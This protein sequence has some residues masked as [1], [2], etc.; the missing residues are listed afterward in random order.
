NLY[1]ADTKVRD[2]EVV[3]ER[4]DNGGIGHSLQLIDGTEH[5][6]FRFV[7]IVDNRL[8]YR[9]VAR[10]GVGARSEAERILLQKIIRDGQGT[11]VVE[12]LFPGGGVAFE[13]LKDLDFTLV[14]S[15]FAGL[16]NI[17]GDQ[18]FV[19]AGLAVPLN[20]GVLQAGALDL[21]VDGGRIGSMRVLHVDQRPAA[22]VDAQ[23]D[24][25]PERHGKH[26]SHAEDQREGQEVPLLPKEIDVRV[27]K[28]FHAAYDPF[29]KSVVSRQSSVVSRQ[30]LVV[31]GASFLDIRERL[32]TNDQRPTTALNTQRFSAL[33]PAQ[34]PIK[35]HARYKHRRKQVCRQAEH[36]RR[37]KTLYRPGT[38]DEKNRGRSNGRDVGIDDGD[39]GMAEAL[40]HRRG[41]RL[42]VPQ[43]FPYA[44]K[45]QH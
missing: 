8:T 17:E 43:L 26:S 38:E 4:G 10:V 23:R 29:K 22:E 1:V 24:A 34:H 20:A 14:E 7:A 35:N 5:T 16:L 39:P 2:V 30:S 45:N 18:H 33:L 6:A 28:E 11:G 41:R 15:L 12:I 31:R 32:M 36:Q 40:L 44:L 21:R 19:I 9:S 37:R 27:S 3:L 25:V 42:A 13:R